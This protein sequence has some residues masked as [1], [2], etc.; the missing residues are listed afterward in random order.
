MSPSLLRLP[1][2]LPKID[3]PSPCLCLVTNRQLIGCEE[4]LGAIKESVRGGVNMVQ[5]REKDLPG[6][7]LADL[8]SRLSEVISSQTLLI[9]N[10]RIDVAAITESHGVQLGE[11]GLSTDAARAILGR[12]VLVGRSVHSVEG[13]KVAEKEGADFLLAGTMFPSSTH[14]GEEVAGPRL[15]T[16]ITSECS[17]PIIAIG[18][19]NE[20]N[21]ASV[22]EAGA[23]GVAV[24]SG[25]LKSSDPN[26]TARNLMDNMLAAM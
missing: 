2:D 4:M 25:I 19:I 7:R 21:V 12:D 3:I 13:A 14:P 1:V 17:L 15:V 22:I 8:A 6:R 24:I 10:E 5:L 11:E 16:S 26:L 18:G 9:I 20:S 23:Q